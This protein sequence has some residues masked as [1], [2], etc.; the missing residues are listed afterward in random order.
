MLKKINIRNIHSLFWIIPVLLIC[1]GQQ[2]ERKRETRTFYVD[3]H[4]GNDQADGLSP[5]AA[6][7]TFSRIRQ[8]LLGPGDSLLFRRGSSFT[9]PL[10]IQDNGL[11]GKPIVLAD[12]G[13]PAQPAPAFT[14]PEFKQGNF[15]NCIRVKGS[16]VV[17]EN[18]YFHKTS[19]YRRGTYTPAQGWDTT[20]WEMGAV[21]ID[22]TAKDCRVRNNEF[23]D[24]VVGIKSYGPGMKAERNLLR[25]CNR[26]LKEWGWGPIAIW[27]GGDRQEAAY[28]T[29]INYS[30]VD[31]GI[32]WDEGVG[33]GADGGAFEIDDARY[34]KKDI[35]IHHNYSRD[36]QGFLEVTWT[37]IKQHPEYRGFRIHHN[38]SDDYQQF[39][40]MWNGTEAL[41]EHNTIVRRKKN[42]NDWGV[43]NI[44]QDN[45]KNVVRNNIIVTEKDI[46]IFNTGLR[47]SKKPNTIITGNLY[48]A[49]S[50]NLVMGKEGPGADPVYGDP[51]FARYGSG[52]QATDYFILAGS[53]A[54]DKA[55]NLL[56]DKDF[57][58]GAVPV[59]DAPDIGAVE[60][61]P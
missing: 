1:C 28:N 21:Y 55:K 44:T 38:I 42:V 27:F 11:P 22:K 9:G 40:A 10:L 30:A 16:N 19:A 29:I 48:Y 31:P 47:M 46:P 14:N 5:S 43:F 3:S 36:C 34:P 26:V 20:V 58:G 2:H 41:I 57:T 24:C 7:K 8:G 51:K 37:D 61:R 53:A 6:W 45:S 4:A 32:H 13:D 25:D 35:S 52:L 17:V 56:Y 33:G 18:M 59:G 15:G 50:G 60:Y 23:V 54:I 49:A 12:Y 39:I